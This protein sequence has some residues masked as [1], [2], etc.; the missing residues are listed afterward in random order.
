MKP[1]GRAYFKQ[2]E[3][4]KE[5]MHPPKGYIN[6]WEDIITPNKKRNN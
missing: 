4:A 1:L 3:R 2:P 6:W 5:D